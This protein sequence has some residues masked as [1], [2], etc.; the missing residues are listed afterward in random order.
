[1]NILHFLK[2]NSGKIVMG[3]AQKAALTAG[4]GA[5]VVGGAYFIGDK[6]G[7]SEPQAPVRGYVMGAY[8]RQAETPSTPD[9]TIKIAGAK[10][11]TSVNGSYSA[12]A[13]HDWGADDASLA[14]VDRIGAGGA[15]ANPATRGMAGRSEGLGGNNDI[16]MLNP[17]GDSTNNG[18]ALAAA[19]A[20]GGARAAAAAQRGVMATASG[21]VSGNMYGG[22]S[23]RSG[24][25]ARGSVNRS[26]NSLGTAG[27]SSNAYRLSGAMPEGSTLLAS[28]KFKEVDS[29]F[30]SSR[31]ARVGR[32][33]QSGDGRTL[34]QIT[35]RSAE[36]AKN[37]HRSA[38]EGG[39]AFLASSQNSGGIQL[40]DGS[41]L[42]EGNAISDDFE[43]A[44]I[45]ARNNL[46]T[47]MDDLMEE[48]LQRRQDR[49]R[50]QRSLVAL[51]FLLI[52]AV[53]AIGSLMQAFRDN[54]LLWGAAVAA[55]AVGVAMGVAI[56]LF[57]ADAGK[58]IKKWGGN[59]YATWALVLGPIMLSLVAISYIKKV[60]KAISNLVTDINK[61]F[62]GQV[63]G[64]AGAISAGQGA[65]NQAKTSI[66][67]IKSSN[68]DV[69]DTDLTQS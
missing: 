68:Q 21:G 39:R 16:V 6:S 18:K 51:V 1:M 42:T 34:R 35:K 15:G 17:K 23:S 50:L 22:A 64:G 53:L 48:E 41:Q 9:E 56:G 47:T 10:G 26:G 29:S 32:G 5:A 59:P 65:F 27:G 46:D 19:G 33:M 62:G 24:S 7:A 30:G 66:Q 2:S 11:I 12:A 40:E 69:S 49:T 55:A 8:G 63:V 37:T 58:F 13:G 25:G 43:E 36:I 52:P 38:N 28:A 14:A 57:M 45:S 54:H 3:F 60:S 61:F 67:G 20:A 44:N 31:G 4:L